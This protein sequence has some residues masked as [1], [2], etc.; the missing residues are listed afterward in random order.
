MVFTDPNKNNFKAHSQKNGR[1]TSK[2]TV[3]RIEE[4]LQS[5]QSEELTGDIVV[6]VGYAQAMFL[7]T[8]TKTTS[9]YTIGEVVVQREWYPCVRAVSKDESRIS[10]QVH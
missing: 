10:L 3:R 4:Q 9:R 1:T 6:C 5:T 7:L 2:H 8:P